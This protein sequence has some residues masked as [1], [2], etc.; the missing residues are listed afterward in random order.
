MEEEP[1]TCQ[2]LGEG[3]MVSLPLGAPYLGAQ[4]P[5]NFLE[6][7]ILNLSLNLEEAAEQ[8][9]SHLLTKS[10]RDGLTPLKIWGYLL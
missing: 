3:H 2:E 6:L 10:S 4:R 5:P 1:I 8:V 7:F 9:W